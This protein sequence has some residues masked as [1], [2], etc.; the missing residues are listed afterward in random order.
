MTKTTGGDFSALLKTAFCSVAP[1]SD[2][3]A[4]ALEAH[5]RRYE[6]WNR[7]LNLSS[8][9]DMDS[10][11]VRHY[12]ESLFLAKHLPEGPLRVVDVGSGAGFPGIPV[13]VVRPDCEVVLV[14]GHQRKAV[15]LKEATRD[16][17]NVRVF[18]ARAEQLDAPFDWMLSRAVAWE[19][20]RPHF[21]RLARA[22]GLLVGSPDAAEISQDA[23][24]AWHVP[25]LLPW[26][27]QR[28][29][30]TGDCST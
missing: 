16:L 8:I 27:R 20:L 3:E 5:F 30:L 28:V 1:I 7:V 4:A 12:C 6:Q 29:L 15:F 2:R 11:I 23:V 13:A 14:E 24:V 10:V 19:E 18:S 26:G 22:V 21:V 17:P 9:H 25:I